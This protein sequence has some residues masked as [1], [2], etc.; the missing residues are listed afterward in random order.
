ML[1]LLSH[2]ATGHVHIVNDSE[3]TLIL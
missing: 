3:A 2:E 1:N